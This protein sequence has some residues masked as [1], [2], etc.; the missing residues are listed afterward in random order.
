MV[1]R[2]I[3]CKSG[4]IHNRQ[5]GM[6][7]TNWPEAVACSHSKN[8]F[9]VSSVW[10]WAFTWQGRPRTAWTDTNKTWKS[11]SEWQR[12]E[13]NGTERC[14]QPSNRR[15]LKNRTLPRHGCKVLW[16]AQLYVRLSISMQCLF[17][18]ISQNFTKLSVHVACGHGSALLRWQC[19]M[20]YISG[21]VDDVI[22]RVGHENKTLLNSQY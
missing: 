3:Y 16:W 22:Y 8:V 11:Q 5:T 1:N 13:I 18:C 6:F 19:N 20:L 9:Y 12:T 10:I 2:K 4:P 21:F 15:R 17:A 14:S 7:F